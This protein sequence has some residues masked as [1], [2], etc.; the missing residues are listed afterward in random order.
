[1]FNKNKDVANCDC[2]LQLFPSRDR[3]VQSKLSGKTVNLAHVTAIM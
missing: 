1:M 3:S 2:L